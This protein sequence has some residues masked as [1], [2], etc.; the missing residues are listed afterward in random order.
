M[1]AHLH[2]SNAVSDGPLSSIPQ[3][4]R[5]CAKRDSYYSSSSSWEVCSNL[6]LIISPSLILGSTTKAPEA[7]HDPFRATSD[8][9]DVRSADEGNDQ[10]T[11]FGENP[12]E[13]DDADQKLDQFV[14]GELHY[15][16]WR[17][18]VQFSNWASNIE[19]SPPESRM[20]DQLSIKQVLQYHGLNLILFYLYSHFSSS[21]GFLRDHPPVPTYSQLKQGRHQIYDKNSRTGRSNS[22]SGINNTWLS[23]E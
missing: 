4:K 8:V 5:A 22:S 10:T 6:R 19:I 3:N 21:L 7:I 17:I 13:N 14:E 23:Q 20:C 9:E 15:W 12:I 16:S 1:S 11:R 18:H 2:P